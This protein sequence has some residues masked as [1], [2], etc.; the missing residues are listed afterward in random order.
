M[1]RNYFYRRSGRLQHVS[2]YLALL[3]Y[4]KPKPFKRAATKPTQATP[5]QRAA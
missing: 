1:K 4:D 5:R 2:L 3:A